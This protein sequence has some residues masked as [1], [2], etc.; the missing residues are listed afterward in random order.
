MPGPADPKR[1]KAA[2][3][4]PPLMLVLTATI[5]PPTIFTTCVSILT[6]ATCGSASVTAPHRPLAHLWSRI[7]L[8]V[9]VLSLLWRDLLTLVPS[10][11]TDATIGQAR[12]SDGIGFVGQSAR[13][14]A[15]QG[16]SWQ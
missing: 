3:P 5:V 4:P 1:S 13:R 12:R 8:D 9:N 14:R 7:L 10:H 15:R 2:Y 6:A 16:G 11:E